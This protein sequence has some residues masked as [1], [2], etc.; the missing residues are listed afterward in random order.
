M[1]KVTEVKGKQELHRPN[2]ALGRPV[3]S[4]TA[5][6]TLHP[7]QVVSKDGYLWFLWAES[8]QTPDPKTDRYMGETAGGKK[9]ELSLQAWYIYIKHV[10]SAHEQA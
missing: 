4:P 7:P 9:L 1:Q 8:R 2:L 6:L 3:P 10:S 5:Q